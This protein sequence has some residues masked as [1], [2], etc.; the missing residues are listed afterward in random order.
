MG[1]SLN[2]LPDEM[3]KMLYIL[4]VLMIYHVAYQ[5]NELNEQIL[6]YLLFSF[7]S[8]TDLL[9]RSAGPPVKCG[10]VPK[11]AITSDRIV[12]WM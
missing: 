3:V 2:L 9:T 7:A 5:K 4:I 1:P 8:N 12:S 11:M 10:C 6:T